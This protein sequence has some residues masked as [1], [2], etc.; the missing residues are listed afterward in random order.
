MILAI[1]LSLSI[2]NHSV[3]L[4]SVDMIEINHKYDCN[5]AF[6]FSQ[7]IFWD[8]D[9]EHCEY[10]CRAWTMVDDERKYPRLLG[11]RVHVRWNDTVNHV[12]RDVHATHFRES[13]THNDPERDNAMKYPAY[14]REGFAK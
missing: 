9:C 4:S 13:W 6:S 1:L 10:K 3:G 7:V 5:G 8:W 11:N 2:L 12:N 14:H